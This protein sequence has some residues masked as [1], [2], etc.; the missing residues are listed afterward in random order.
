[1]IGPGHISSRKPN[2]DA[3]SSF[4][5]SFCDGIVVSDG[6]GSKDFSH[7]GSVAACMAVERAV[8]SIWTDE[9]DSVD[10][11]FLDN[12]R[13]YWLDHVGGLEPR[14]AAAT[15]L[16]AMVYGSMTWI[17]QLGDGCAAAIRKDGRVAVLSDDKSGSFSNMTESLSANVSADR[18]RLACIPEEQVS[19]LVL[20]TDGI[21]DD[22]V[23]LDK[24]QGFMKG[25]A[26]SS[27]GVASVVAARE[28]RDMLEH[29][30]TPKHTDDKTIACLLKKEMEHE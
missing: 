4:H 22:I 11:D 29:W 27:A 26:E 18:W 3:W 10:E 15:C 2:Q 6:L 7:L 9:C 8:F 13:D 23:G 12:I 28:A 20:C 5:H 16:F 1:M 19:A 14:S 24:L 25:F 21:S 17:G 30:P